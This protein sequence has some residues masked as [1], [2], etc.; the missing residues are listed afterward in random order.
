[1]L[2][3]PASTT[4]RMAEIF[5]HDP[6]GDPDPAAIRAATEALAAGGLVVLPTETV[7]GIACR[8]DLPA[9]TGRL[10]TAKRRARGLALPVMTATATEALV[11]AR[12]DAAARVM[13][14]AFWPGPLTI[15]LG[16]SERAAGWAL[17]EHPDTIALRVP[18]HRSR[19]RCCRVAVRW[20]SA[21]RTARAGLRRRPRRSS[22]THSATRWTSSSRNRGRYRPL[23]TPPRPSSISP[24]ER[25][26]SCERAL[27]ERRQSEPRSLTR[28]WRSTG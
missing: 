28:A 7:Y 3:A 1:M 14:G 15:V 21:A 20:P 5:E 25:R 17:G 10:F 26:A 12:P 23:R 24:R 19:R 18:A 9:A 6:E 13:A 8:A 16:R 11:L 27:S 22:W 4:R 2:G